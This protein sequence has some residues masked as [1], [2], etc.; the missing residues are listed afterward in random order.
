MSRCI[1]VFWFHSFIGFFQR[2]FFKGRGHPNL[3]GGG[4]VQQLIGGEPAGL[5]TIARS[6]LNL[7]DG[8]ISVE[9]NSGRGGLPDCSSP[10]PFQ[11]AE[12]LVG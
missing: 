8:R 3:R 2:F 5:F 11:S 12:F 4:I 6:P 9:V 7:A 10:P 1:H